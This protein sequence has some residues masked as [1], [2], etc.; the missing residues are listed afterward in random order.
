[1]VHRETVTLFK[2][3]ASWPEKVFQADALWSE[4]SKLLMIY[5][6]ALPSTLR[7]PDVRLVVENI[8]G[9]D[10]SFLNPANHT[11][12]KPEHIPAEGDLRAAMLMMKGAS[13][14]DQY[15]KAHDLVVEFNLATEGISTKFL[16]ALRSG[17]LQNEIQE[18][19]GPASFSDQMARLEDVI[20]VDHQG[21][22]KQI[23][24]L[25]GL[26]AAFGARAATHENVFLVDCP[27]SVEGT[28]TTPESISS[29]GICVAVTID[30]HSGAHTTK[31]IAVDVAKTYYGEYFYYMPVAI[32]TPN[33]EVRE[34]RL[35]QKQQAGPKVSL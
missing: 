30:P 5:K 19:Y 32:I 20:W 6:T 3:G 35:P 22:S 18:A 14:S 24:P 8:S 26:H 29:E 23:T 17:V 7:R 4:V 21:E 9:V 10:I 25:L 15:K 33:G 16:T 12:G 27:M 2:Q 13:L 11:N 28:Q 1:M 34:L 31:P